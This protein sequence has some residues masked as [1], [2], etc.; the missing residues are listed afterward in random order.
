MLL[1]STSSFR[2]YWLHKIFKLVAKTKYDWI[3]L[4]I[5]SWDYDS[6][7]AQYIKSLSEEFK[8]PVLSITAYER[9]MDSD[10]VD[11]MLKFAEI[12]WA[13]IINFYPPH[14][15]DKDTTWFSEYLQKIK[16]KNKSL[17]L[18]VINVEPKTFLLF[19]PEYKDA[20]LATIK[21]VT[22]DTTLAVSNIDTSTWVDLLKAFSVLGSSIKN[23]ILSDRSGAKTD[24]LLGRWDMP[25]ES[26][27]IKLKENLYKWFFTLKIAPKELWVGKDELVLKRL[28]E[29]R[30]FFERYYK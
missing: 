30:Q 8:V 9:K 29:S 15:A 22:W 28:E 6:E 14:R 1:V 16:S 27:L 4:D 10:M 24:L 25:L 17:N 2:G 13:K 26:L 21:K 11:A 20:T 3:N 23:V 18:A 19:I 7:D 5:A 12:L